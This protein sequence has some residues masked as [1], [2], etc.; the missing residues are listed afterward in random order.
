MGSGAWN[1]N[2]EDCARRG[3]SLFTAA[4][5]GKTGMTTAVFSSG[6]DTVFARLQPS[7]GLSDAERTR[8]MQLVLAD[9]L[10]TQAME[11]MAG[12]VFLTAFAVAL[13]ASNLT[14]GILAAIPALAQLMQVP[15]VVLVERLRAR[16]FLV[17]LGA[18]VGRVA[19]VLLA[20]AIIHALT[21]SIAGCS[22]NS[23]MRDLLP[24]DQLNRFF[25]RRMMYSTLLGATLSAVIAWLLGIGGDIWPDQRIAHFSVLFMA[26]GLAGL[27]GIALVWRT[28]E[29][30]MHARQSDFCMRALLTEPFQTRNY[31]RLM[32]FLAAWSFAV[33]LAT[34]FFAVYMLK[35]L[36]LDLTIVMGLVIL[37]QLA[38][39]AALRIWARTADRI[40]SK[41]VLRRAGFLFLTALAAWMLTWRGTTTQ[42]LLTLVAI[43]LLLGAATAGVALGTASLSLK[44]SPAGRAT[45]F[46]AMNA[47][48]SAVAGGLAPIIGGASADFFATRELGITIQWL[49]PAA[50]L[51]IPALQMRHW[52]FYFAMAFAIGVFALLRLRR[53]REPHPTRR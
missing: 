10:T 35:T 51:S 34:P 1:N 31:R 18:G 17:V 42:T 20:A 2:R 22:W 41:R 9:G 21:G 50:D 8:G 19:M 52:Q 13:G 3:Y 44:L 36:S 30:Q 53:V 39:V 40:G 46:L 38:H 24:A 25:A 15:G 27:V 49:S 23:W 16:R 5:G 48:T 6:V 11:T 32:V 47:V 14:I 28:P 26:G 45:P 33:N 43:H 29:P 4:C 7:D 37:S 12:G